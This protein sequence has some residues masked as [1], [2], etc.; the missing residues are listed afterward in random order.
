[1]ASTYKTNYLGLNKFVGSNKPKMD[2]FN[3]DNETLDQKFQEHVQ[4]SLH[5][6]EEERQMLGKANYVI[7]T[8]T[9][10]GESPRT[11]DV[12]FDVEFGIIFALEEP[13]SMLHASAGV[14]GIYAAFITQQGCSK[15]VYT[16]EN[17]FIVQQTSINPPDGKKC[18]LNQSG[19]TY[20]TGFFQRRHKKGLWQL[21]QT[22]LV[23]SSV[24]FCAGSCNHFHFNPAFL[25]DQNLSGFAAFKRTNDAFFFHGI[26]QSGCTCIS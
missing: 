4:S 10:N 25:G 1:M 20:I 9:G 8:Y 3:F 24:I 2:V 5:I 6:T 26:H 16:T 23:V 19:S 22:F 14:T 17:G 12:G 13:I 21:P 18:M 15:G 7:G 11:I